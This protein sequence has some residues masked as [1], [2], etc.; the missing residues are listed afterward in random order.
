VRVL[1]GVEDS[2]SLVIPYLF[3]TSEIPDGEE[4]TVT[5]TLRFRHLP[6]EFIRSLAEEQEDLDNVPP[7]ARI[8]DPQDLVD[9]LTITNVVTAETGDGAVIA[10]EGPQNDSDRTIL[11]CV[12]DVEGDEA[13]DVNAAVL[14]STAARERALP[15]LSSG[16]VVGGVTAL[17]GF[18]GLRRRDRR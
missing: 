1:E 7:S 3:D 4:I 8:E 10:C 9:N 11:E 18:L 17:G 6:P 16:L 14:R 12:E 2:T 13:V 15:P 5:A